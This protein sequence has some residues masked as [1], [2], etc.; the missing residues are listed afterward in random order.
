MKN[1]IDRYLYD[2][3][4][5]LPE[6]IRADV[7]REL[8]SNIEDMLSESPSETEIEQVITEL[9]SPAK[10]AVQY[11]PRPRYLISPEVFDDYLMVLKIVAV[12]LGALLAALAIFKFIFSDTGGVSADNVAATI[13]AI[14][15]DFV[16]GAWT[17]IV[18]AFFW[19]TVIFSA[20]EYVS[21]K[22]GMPT[23]SPKNLPDIPKNSSMIIKR[24]DSIANAIFATLF[25]ALFLVG[26]IRHPQFIAWYETG[27]PAAPLFNEQIVLHYLPLFIFMIVFTL[28][29]ASLKLIYGR[30]SVGIAASQ[31]LYSIFSAVIGVTFITQQ[32][33]LT[34]A[35]ITRFADKLHVTGTIMSGYIK[36]GIT[37]IIV[38]IIIGT[39][40]E[41]ISAIEKTA[42]S[43]K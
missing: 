8:R 30:W 25:S 7:E 19:V 6:N 2:V 40:G 35:F 31:S 13:A 14:I 3:S 15:T 22:K 27:M 26:T 39:I 23:W 38:L 10:L 41:I 9:G 5:R 17:G 24:G 33:V 37:V 42:K 43:Y 28:F 20:V 32:N 29:I 4:R 21:R 18:Q 34:D 1:M 11:N 12:I 16:S 36:T